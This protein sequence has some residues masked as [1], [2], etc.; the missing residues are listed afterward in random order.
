[1]INAD[2]KNTVSA[3]KG[4]SARCI[5]CSRTQDANYMAK[6]IRIQENS[7]PAFTVLEYGKPLGT[8][9]LSVPGMHNVSNALCAVAAARY[10]GISFETIQNGLQAFTGV[11]RR[12]EKKGVK[13]GV[14]VID[15]Y[16]HHPTEIS[17][18][19]RIASSFV[20][21]RVFCVFQPHTYTRTKTLFDDFVSVFQGISPLVLDIYAAREKDTGIV[22]SMDLVHAIPGATYFPSFDA[23]VSYLRENAKEGDMLL[24]V[25]AGDVYRVG[26]LFLQNE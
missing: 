11:G 1:V 19:L 26:E 10:L 25:G 21:G 6:E 4:T 17:A 16:A 7:C 5:T 9:S 22:S 15:D 20:P 18:T 23:C 2:D 3:V 14:T 24:T 12:F 8:V 13:N